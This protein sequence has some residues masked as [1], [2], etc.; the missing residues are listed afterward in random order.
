MHDFGLDGTR[1]AGAQVGGH[2]VGHVVEQVVEHVVGHVVGQVVEQAERII[3]RE[4]VPACGLEES[5]N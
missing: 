3:F 5:L 2:V 4:E 1:Q